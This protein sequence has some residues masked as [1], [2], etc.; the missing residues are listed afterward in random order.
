[1]SDYGGAGCCRCCFSFLL[2]SGLTTLF[3]WLSLHTSKP[4]CS[5]QDFYVSA[6]NKTLNSTSNH[7]IF[8]DLKLENQN[9]DKGVYYDAINLTFYYG[10]NISLP[11]ANYTVSGFH[12]GHKK[13]THRKDLVDARG[14]PWD[15]VF[16]GV[17]NGSV[18][19]FR[20]D[21]ATT[22]RFKV[23]SWKTKR[24][25]LDLKG[26]VK[27]DDSGKKVETKGIKLKN[28]GQELGCY[29]A[30]LRVLVV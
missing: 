2:T 19:V 14:V 21:L 22:V 20:V 27:V 6:L 12:Q 8:F 23:I 30:R 29:L 24:H 18:A 7:S 1:M 11:I 9:I 17:S 26:N 5:I 3:L 25:K 16:R 10:P 28:G 13:Y 4:V 15:E